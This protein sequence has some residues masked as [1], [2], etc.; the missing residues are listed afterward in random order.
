MPECSNCGFAS[1]RLIGEHRECDAC[2]KYRKRHGR[3]RPQALLNRA[4]D[5]REHRMQRTQEREILKANGWPEPARR[6]NPQNFALY[7][8]GVQREVVR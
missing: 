2:W 7:P 4:G 8:D 3:A 5:R 1:S 6:D